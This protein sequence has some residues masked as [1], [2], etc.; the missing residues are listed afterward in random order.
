MDNA[1][2]SLANPD[3]SSVFLHDV[4][5]LNH[6]VSG[7]DL[8]LVQLKPGRLDAMLSQVSLADFPSTRGM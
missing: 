6:A 8:E 7:S 2:A 4:D 5:E 3:P 1:S